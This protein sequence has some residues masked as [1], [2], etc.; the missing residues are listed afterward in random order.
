MRGLPTSLAQDG[1]WLTS[2]RPE[3][4]TLAN[5]PRR[6]LFTH[7]KKLNPL[8]ASLAMLFLLVALADWLFWGHPVGVSL[9]I[10]V[11]A[12]FLAS[13]T[14]RPAGRVPAGPFVLLAI[15]TL[16]VIEH[17]QALSLG[18]QLAGLVF[19]IAWM[20]LRSQS[21]RNAIISAGFA[22]IRALPSHGLLC[23]FQQMNLQRQSSKVAG[24]S[25]PLKAHL[26]NWAFPFGGTLVLAV[27]LLEANPLLEQSLL[28]LADI[29]LDLA[30]LLRRGIFW[31]GVA[32]IL[33]PCLTPLAKKTEAQ[34]TSSASLKRKQIPMGLNGGSVLR[35]LLMFNVILSVQT[36]MDFSILFGGAKLPKGMTLATYAH[37]G[38]YP[39]LA[40][41]MLAGGFALAA[42]PYLN[43]HR[44]LKPLMLIWLGQNAL[45]GL[46]SLLRLDLYVGS[47][48]LTYLR[49]YAMIWMGLV[50]TGLVLTAWQILRQN[51]NTWLLKRCL[52]LGVGTLYIC[53]F[54]NFA[55]IIAG[56]NL[57]MKSKHGPDWYYLCDLGPLAAPGIEK[58]L[59]ANPNL[60]LPADYASC[61]FVQ[62]VPSNWREWGFRSWRITSYADVG[63]RSTLSKDRTP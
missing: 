61:W 54:I 38:A 49:C 51:S 58:A 18:F 53:A 24:L 7:G 10:F 63:Y 50:V 46:S 14:L 13:A 8:F 27:L 23:L 20:H 59:A 31:L 40:T 56:Q 26:S 41:A 11:W 32:L 21:E 33:W 35:A 57:S 5:T 55:S 45:L 43:S 2:D 29:D 28:N 1:W 16:P 44:S 30:A 52:T 36:V 9:S 25:A 4:T 3:N 47:F 62:K 42:R 17:F 19:S 34:D 60:S 37:R 22:L 39:L 48:G 12:V 6:G 15:C